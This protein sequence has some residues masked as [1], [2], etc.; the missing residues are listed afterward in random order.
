[1]LMPIYY[2]LFTPTNRII[3]EYINIEIN[4]KQIENRIYIISFLD[5]N[6]NS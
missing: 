6:E 1:M 5:T 2:T 3:K 4:L